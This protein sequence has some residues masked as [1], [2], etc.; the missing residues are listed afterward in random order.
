MRLLIVYFMLLAVSASAA[1]L[2]LSVLAPTHNADNGGRCGLPDSTHLNPDGSLNLGTPL[3]DLK[4]IRLYG[5][6]F[7][8]PDTLLIGSIPAL[9]A[10][11]DTIGV[12]VEITPG[13]MG[14][15]FTRAVDKAGNVSCIGAQYVFALPAIDSTLVANLSPHYEIIYRP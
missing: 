5:R 9:G 13:T 3:T 7:S 2:R 15:F 4:E 6:K 1:T 14:F 10:E 11:G 12:D 8:Q